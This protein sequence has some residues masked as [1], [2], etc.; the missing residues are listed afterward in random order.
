MPRDE[1]GS[2]ADRQAGTAPPPRSRSTGS[3]GTQDER[4]AKS[5]A[6][7]EPRL[8]A[9]GE[10]W[11]MWGIAGIGACLVLGVLGYTA[12]EGATTGS[13]PP[14]V[15][16]HIEDVQHQKS[17]GY[18]VRVRAVNEGGSTAAEL[19]VE[20]ALR[21]DGRTV[22]VSDTTFDYVP[23]NSYRRGGLFFRQDPRS[24]EIELRA[25]GYSDP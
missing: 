2:S 5:G 10:P 18:L 21:R 22:E 3:K 7:S 25:V 14:S 20:G 12:Y 9:G 16:L 11:W 8:G 6:G 23:A 15:V 19:K 24:A 17:G 13:T 1:Q 4:D